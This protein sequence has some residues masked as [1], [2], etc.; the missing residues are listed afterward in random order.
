MNKQKKPR[1]GKRGAK[2]RSRGTECPLRDLK[3]AQA[4]GADPTP[5]PVQGQGQ[6]LGTATVDDEVRCSHLNCD[7]EKFFMS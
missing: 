5:A 6:C 3:E 4:S 2:G 1:G 7:H